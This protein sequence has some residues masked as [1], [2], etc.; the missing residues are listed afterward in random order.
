[1]SEPK[2]K[3][4]Y[5]RVG[6]PVAFAVLPM[7]L[8]YTGNLNEVSLPDLLVP[9]L[10]LLAASLPVWW[11][12]V[13]LTRDPHRGA[14]LASLCWVWFFAYGFWRRWIAPEEAT[15][16]LM[17]VIAYLALLS[18]PLLLVRLRRNYAPAS[19]AL[20][21]VALGLVAVQLFTIGR[22]ELRRLHYRPEPRPAATLHTTVPPAQRPSIYFIILDGY[23]RHDVLQE[24]Y[25]VDNGPF[26]AFLRQHGFQVAARSRANYDQTLLSLASCLDLNYLDGLVA[27]VGARSGYRRPLT[28]KMVTS[29]TRTSLKEL[30]YDFVSFASGYEESDM[31]EAAHRIAHHGW[32]LNDFESALAQN[33]VLWP[34]LGSRLKLVLDD[35]HTRAR[36]VQWI[37]E[38]LP[39][40]ARSRR[41]TFVFAHIV[42]P[43]PPFIFR[44]DG[45]I[46]A[47]LPHPGLHD[48]SRFRGTREEYI[49]SYREQAEFVT[50]R[51]QAMVEQLLA[52][53]RRPTAIV[54]MSD[55]G[56]ASGV[57]WAHPETS[58]LRE[59]FTTLVA[60][61][62][63]EGNPA[64]LDDDISTVN[65]LRF[66]LREG[67]GA[68]LPPLPS[69]SYFSNYEN[70]YL[71]TEIAGEEG[72]LPLGWR[73][74]RRR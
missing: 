34:L 62:L 73:E 6:S 43:H 15:L 74:R 45:S 3:R 38:H 65:V 60:V 39:A 23:A 24:V 56:P 37:F 70:P 30:G 22:F 53:A 72:R 51:T 19:G 46:I 31:P 14:V 36:A 5:P 28:E 57:D 64:R 8:L 4:S 41:P 35:D 13:R 71:L 47:H 17:T 2:P 58:D 54:L 55:H 27:K 50:W 48:G 12:A 63:P 52:S 67:L 40:T 1:M 59:R 49:A 68:D 11:L 9:A 16:E 20:N 25:G 7:L 66:V 44:R 33:S 61:R 69:R 26:L 18:V 29:R 10:V 42:A 32:E 21:V